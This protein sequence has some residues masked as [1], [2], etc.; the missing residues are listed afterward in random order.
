MTASAT[1]Y[2]LV[3]EQVRAWPPDAR[4]SLAEDLLRSLHHDVRPTLPR[5]VP[6][7]QVLGVAAGKG[8]PP[9]DETVRRWIEEY[10][11]EKYG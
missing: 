11:L 3:L 1:D 10:R 5:G 2:A 8:P 6:V 9:D 4:L 7:E